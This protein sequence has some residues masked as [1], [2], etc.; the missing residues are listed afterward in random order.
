M[1][2]RFTY[3]IERSAFGQVWVL[4][5]ALEQSHRHNEVCW[6]EAV[7][8]QMCAKLNAQHAQTKL[9]FS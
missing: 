4:R 3:E 2:K 8:K 7:A 5:D 1:S 9:T 6:S